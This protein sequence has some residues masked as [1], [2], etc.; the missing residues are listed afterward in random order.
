VSAPPPTR[1]DWQELPLGDHLLAECPRWDH[2][3]QRLSWV[4]ILTGT[5]GTARLDDGHWGAVERRAVG[6]MPT[7]A[8]P[9]PG[10]AALAVAVDGG[11]VVVEPGGG[12]RPPIPVSPGFPEVRT[13]DMTVDGTGRL[14]VGLFTEDRVS[15]RGGVVAVDL[16][17]RSVTP[18]VDG[19]VTANG[20]AVTPDGDALYAVDT[21]RGTLTRHRLDPDATGRP[22]AGEVLVEHAGPG[23]LDGLALG[24]DGD[25]WVAVWDA[26]ALHRY[27]PS[28]RL[29]DVLAVP[30]PR[31][32]AVAVVPLGEQPHLVVTTART[33]PAP[34]T[35]HGARLAPS[36]EGRLYATPLP[37]R[38]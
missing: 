6:T 21:A 25:V 33:R 7:A 20:L 12:I 30:V 9:L 16:S 32:S 29:R 28:G 18:L 19:Y 14:L 11:V 27:A 10:R 4:D 17:E 3:L 13:N 24:P 34:H 38:R 5:V 1:P 37:D 36:P 31:A 26:G 2:E 8:E 22:V 23:R 15:P 35:G